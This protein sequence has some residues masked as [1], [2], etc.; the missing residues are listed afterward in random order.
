MTQPSARLPGPTPE[1][2]PTRLGRF[3]LLRPLGSGGMGKVYRAEMVA[4]GGFRKVCAVKLLPPSQTLDTDERDTALRREARVGALLHHPHI[5]EIYDFGLSDGQPW[6]S[7]ELVEGVDLERLV[8]A[9][10]PLPGVVLI[11]AALQICDGLAHAHGARRDGREVGLVHRDLKPSNILLSREGHV[12][13]ADFGVAKASFDSTVATGAGVAKGTPAYMSPE[14][15]RGLPVDRRSDIF[16]LGAVFYW[17]ACG[18]VLFRGRTPAAAGA[19]ILNV[20]KWIRQHAVLAEIDEK[21]PGLAPILNRMLQKDPA[22]RY[23]DARTL[24][25]DLDALRV[26]HSAGPSAR[27]WMETWSELFD[28]EASVKGLRR[29]LKAFDLPAPAAAQAWDTDPHGP[30]VTERR[31]VEDEV[32]GAPVLA[33]FPARQTLGDGPGAEL[34]DDALAVLPSRHVVPAV[35]APAEP[36]APVAPN[37]FAREFA[38]FVCGIGVGLV[39]AVG[40]ASLSAD[41]DDVQRAEP[42]P[43]ADAAPLASPAPQVVAVI[44]APTPAPQPELPQ[45][46][47]PPPSFVSQPPPGPA[48]VR[49]SPRVP[50]VSGPAAVAPS[51]A[52]AE[53]PPAPASISEPAPPVSGVQWDHRP[54]VDAIHGTTRTFVLDVRQGEVRSARL[55][56][57]GAMGI[58]MHDLRALTGGRWVAQAPLSASLGP[59]LSYWF[60]VE[61]ADQRVLRVAP[62]TANAWRLQLRA[63]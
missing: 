56:F 62:P 13:I 15:A 50:D 41:N 49:S 42:H 32:D 59:A 33:S 61:L 51:A 10:G 18:R 63:R 54:L 29:E 36:L 26:T 52:A 48:P 57:D 55:V 4:P 37:A 35:E 5:V 6:M 21:V 34:A 22:R 60:E 14:Q 28:S 23:P 38:I 53:L 47:A 11:D 12:K 8:R 17:M 16:C 45:P 31:F 44:D 27:T 46:V 20:D 30:P 39:L 1:P 40:V 19:A 7:M 9:A 24:A 3:M 43:A 25:A 2:E 58:Q